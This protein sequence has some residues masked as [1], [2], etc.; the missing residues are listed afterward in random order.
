MEITKIYIESDQDG[1]RDWF[2]MSVIK[3]LALI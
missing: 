2:D 1:Y 3:D